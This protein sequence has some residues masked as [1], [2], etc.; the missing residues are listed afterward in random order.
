[1]GT[2]GTKS[3]S[4]KKNSNIG[5][6]GAKNNDNSLIQKEKIMLQKDVI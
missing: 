1:M 6:R 4:R 2:P 3:V 5:K